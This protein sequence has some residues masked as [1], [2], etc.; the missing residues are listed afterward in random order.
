MEVESKEFGIDNNRTPMSLVF[1]KEECTQTLMEFL[2]V[3]D[4]GKVV[5]AKEEAESPENEE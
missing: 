3:T 2:F 1:A 5:R 4:V